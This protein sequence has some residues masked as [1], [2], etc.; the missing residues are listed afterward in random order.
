MMTMSRTAA[1]NSFAVA[2]IGSALLLGACNKPAAA[3]ETK[4]AAVQIGIVRLEP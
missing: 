1:Q 3:P 2:L 4:V